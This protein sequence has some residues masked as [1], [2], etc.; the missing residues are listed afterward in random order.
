M[1]ALYCKLAKLWG[2]NYKQNCTLQGG[3]KAVVIT[4]AFQFL[5]MVAG[6]IAIVIKGVSSSG[7][8][9]HTFK[10]ASEYGRLNFIE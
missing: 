4:D 7:G 10:V 3:L 8:I 9:S 2:K 1:H 6:M 5:M